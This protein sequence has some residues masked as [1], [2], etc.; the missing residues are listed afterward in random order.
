MFGRQ[1]TK[2]TKEVAESKMMQQSNMN[3]LDQR[4][5]TK[6]ITIAELHRRQQQAKKADEEQLSAEHVKECQ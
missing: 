6:F 1:R 2:R 5:T 3:A 4:K